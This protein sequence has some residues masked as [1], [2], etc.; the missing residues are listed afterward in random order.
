MDKDGT[1]IQATFFN[2]AA[3]KFD[4]LIQENKVYLF[5]NG[6]VK[7]AQKKFTSIKNDYS[8]TFDTNADVER[9]DDDKAILKQGF[10]FTNL[11]TIQ[12]MV[13]MQ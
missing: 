5:S 13:Q 7:L 4:S 11:A 12:E 8:I 10:C 3:E 9:V 6:Q 2:D 1:Q